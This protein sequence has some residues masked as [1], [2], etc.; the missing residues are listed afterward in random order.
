MNMYD[1]F[2]DG[3]TGSNSGSPGGYEIF[4][5]DGNSVAANY[6]DNAFYQVDEDNFTGPEYGLDVLCVD[7]VAT[8]TRSQ[9]PSSGSVSSLGV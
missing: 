3:W 2:G 8:R 1:S 5:A 6:I 7:Q 9:V 4:D